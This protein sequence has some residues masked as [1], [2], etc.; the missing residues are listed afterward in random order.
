MREKHEVC[1]LSLALIV[2]Y[3]GARRMER[4]V[5]SSILPQT[6]GWRKNKLLSNTPHRKFRATCGFAVRRRPRVNLTAVSYKRT[7]SCLLASFIGILY[8][9]KTFHTN[10]FIVF[11][12]I[13]S[14]VSIRHMF[15]NISGSMLIDLNLNYIYI[16]IFKY[17]NIMPIM[18]VIFEVMLIC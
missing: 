14:V 18:F 7:A 9:Q 17:N 13:T 2:V 16:Y 15:V 6:F 3:V 8:L 11:V 12:I 10:L 1:S 4:I 5:Q